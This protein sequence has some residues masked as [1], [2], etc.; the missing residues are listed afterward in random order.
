MQYP[1]Y[2]WFHPKINWIRLSR[3]ANA[4]YILKQN[5]DKIDWGHLSTNP[6][7]IHLLECNTNKINWSG[8]SLNPGAIHLLEK[9]SCAPK[10]FLIFKR[11]L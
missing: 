4:I 6:N 11:A 3:N 9:K 10:I 7:A 1:K 2:A 8:L 5:L